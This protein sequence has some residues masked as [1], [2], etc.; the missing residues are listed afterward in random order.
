M[1]VS[2]VPGA[3]V[4]NERMGKP[5]F[6]EERGG[7][8]GILLGLRPLIHTLLDGLLMDNI[9]LVFMVRE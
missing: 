9:S 1:S 2:T 6:E 5:L 8:M 7:M 4:A 3:A